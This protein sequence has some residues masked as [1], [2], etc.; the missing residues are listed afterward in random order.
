MN[1]YVIWQQC[2][3]EARKRAEEIFPPHQYRERENKT[4]ELALLEFWRRTDKDG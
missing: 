3:D 4:Q 1:L 2:L